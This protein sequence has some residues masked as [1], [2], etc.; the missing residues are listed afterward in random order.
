VRFKCFAQ[1]V[2]QIVALVSRNLP[3][4]FPLCGTGYS[5]GLPAEGMETVHVA[6]VITFAAR[7]ERT[8]RFTMTK[9]ACSGIQQSDN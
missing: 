6:R 2:F 1:G 3:L 5:E 8:G 4:L 7:M 9:A